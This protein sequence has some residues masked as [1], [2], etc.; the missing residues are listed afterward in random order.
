MSRYKPADIARMGASARRQIELVRFAEEAR[1]AIAEEKRSKYGNTPTAIDGITFHSKAEAKRYGE[2][3]LLHRAGRISELILQPEFPITV[4]GITVARYLAD[5]QY[6]DAEGELVIEDVKSEGTKGNAVYRLK[7]KLV[8]A[9]H[10][11][12][13]VEVLR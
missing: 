10:G 9:V 13:I 1:G 5:F 7:R 2:L 6:Y 11:I 12:R 4:N 3:K 8:E